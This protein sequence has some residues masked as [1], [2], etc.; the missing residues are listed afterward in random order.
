MKV[1]RFSLILMSITLLAFL[2]HLI[3][4]RYDF[5]IIN[6]SNVLFVVGIIVFMPSLVAMTSSYRVFTSMRYAVRV[7]LSPQFRHEYPTFKDYK[8]EKEKEIKTSL[9][10]ETMLASLIMIVASAILAWMWF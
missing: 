8:S 10:F 9:F 5:S 7:M 3:I 4:Y 1:L 2:L 6:A